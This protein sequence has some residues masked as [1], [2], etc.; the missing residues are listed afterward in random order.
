[1]GE[2]YSIKR[3]DALEGKRDRQEYI[4][5]KYPML[6]D[7]ACI[8]LWFNCLYTMQMTILHLTKREQNIALAFIKKI[9]RQYPIHSRRIDN[10]PLKHRLW[11]YLSE[12]SFV[13]ACKL[14]NLF[15]IGV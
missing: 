3:L 1:M 12:V 13:V 14:R 11:I 7:E 4:E 8:D 5:N 6:A 2:G 15:R 10:L 9:L